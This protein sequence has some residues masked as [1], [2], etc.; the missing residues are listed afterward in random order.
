MEEAGCAQLFKCP[1]SAIHH[2]DDGI[3]V[4]T[5]DG[6]YHAKKAVI[7]VGTWVQALVPELP[8]Q[9]VRKVFRLVS[10]RWA[11]SVKNN[12]PAFTGELPNGDLLLRFPGRKRRAENW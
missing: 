6:D 7:S 9:P 2:G 10:G 3:T 11:H 8:I 12:F 4:E 5:A 1:V